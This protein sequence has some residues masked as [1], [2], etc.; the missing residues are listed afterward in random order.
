MWKVCSHLRVPKGRTASYGVYA[1]QQ[2]PTFSVNTPRKEANWLYG[3]GV[4]EGWAVLSGPHSR[5]LSY[6]CQQARQKG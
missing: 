4:R 1:R 5:N 6:W 2:A 3:R